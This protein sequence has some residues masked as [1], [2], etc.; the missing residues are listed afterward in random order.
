MLRVLEHLNSW[1]LR[2][3][4]PFSAWLF[5]IAHNQLISHVRREAR[6]EAHD[7]AELALWLDARQAR[8]AAASELDDGPATLNG[9]GS[10][11][12]LARWLL[13][14][15][16]PQREVLRLRYVLGLGHREIGLRMDR[17]PEA[18]R[19]LLSRT[20][21]FLEHR[22]RPDS[23]ISRP[24]FVRP[25]VKRTEPH[26]EPCEAAT[27]GGNLEADAGPIPEADARSDGDDRGTD[28]VRT[29]RRDGRSRA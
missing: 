27:E 5:R 3:G 4:V 14:L 25:R 18:V 13:R 28:T 21:S 17:S 7:P 16:A 24:V 26:G 10:E 2:P 1:T 15:S 12:N 9:G 23:E 29:E 6:L 19:K 20:L 22:L 11:P 8:R